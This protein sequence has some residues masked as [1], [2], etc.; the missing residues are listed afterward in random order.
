MGRG[1]LISCRLIQ[2]YPYILVIV[3]VSM[4][5]GQAELRGQYQVCRGSFSVNQ[6]TGSAHV[7][8]HNLRP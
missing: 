1:S 6:G 2:M 7:I 8:N 4:K 5:R 3:E